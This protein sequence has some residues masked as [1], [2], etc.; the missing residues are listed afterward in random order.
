M[1]K[2]WD[3]VAQ[4]FEDCAEE[5]QSCDYYGYEW[6]SDTGADAWCELG[7]KTGHDPKWCPAYDRIKEELEDE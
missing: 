7:E 5:C 1:K 2:D 4:A 3:I 6:S